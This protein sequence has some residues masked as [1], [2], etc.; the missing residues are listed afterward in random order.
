MVITLSFTD[1]MV[2]CDLG[3]YSFSSVPASHSVEAW[4]FVTLDL[5]LLAQFQLPIQLRPVAQTELKSPAS[6]SL[7]SFFI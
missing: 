1:G 3:P 7:G 6:Q 2:F 4:C 5:I